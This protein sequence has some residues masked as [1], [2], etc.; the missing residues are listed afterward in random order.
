M[1]KFNLDIWAPPSWAG[2]PPDIFR[3]EV[4]GLLREVADHL[5]GATLEATKVDVWSRVDGK[6][7]RVGKWRIED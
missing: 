6:A 1:A 5:D 2:I 7:T 3:R 4:A